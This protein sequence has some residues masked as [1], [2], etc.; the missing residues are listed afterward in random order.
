MNIDMNWAVTFSPLVPWS[1]LWAS[2]GVALLLTAILLWRGMRGTWLRV[3]SLILLILAM[4]NPNLRQEQ[5]ETLSNIALVVVDQT[6][7]QKIAGRVKLTED[8]QRQVEERLKDIPNLEVRTI[9]SGQ[10]RDGDRQ[11]GSLLFSD[12]NKGLATIP[13]ERLAG[14]FMITDGQIH[15]VPAKP[16]SLGIDAPVHA[17]ITGKKGEFDRRIEVIEAPRYGIVGD[18]R[19]ISLKVMESGTPAAANLDVTLTIQRE[20]KK[21]ER[22]QVRVGQTIRIPFS[23][24]H[25]GQNILEVT[26]APVNGELTKANNRMVFSAEGVRENLRVLLVSGEPHPGERTWRNLLKSDAS[27]DL[28]HFTILRPPEKQDGTPINQLSLIAFPTREL[29]SE[30]LEEF[31]LIVFDRYKRR[32]VLPLLYLD[33]IA[34]Y[35]EDGGAVLVAAGEAYASTRSLFRTPLAQILPAQP[36]GKL[37][38]VPYH[39]RMTDAGL[40]HPVTR[41]LPGADAKIPRWGR[42]FRTI[43]ADIKEGETLMRGGR[44]KPLL[45][46]NRKGKGRVALLLSDHAWLWARGFDGGGPYTDLL[47]RLAHWLMKEP[48]SGRRILKSVGSDRTADH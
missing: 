13:P 42:W 6:D 23:F 11:D 45:V 34:R 3:L 2:A 7:S 37:I 31:D 39:A 46:L 26:A 8:V 30:K 32:G 10:K 38:E 33:N 29:F 28:V 15:D 16:E 24:P 5:R 27:V 35:V 22:M 14:V 41:D 47:R 20:D 18:E 36:T 17:L 19:Q 12:L 48:G 25:A 9:L 43:E 4:A 21:S 40:K 44:E 1:V